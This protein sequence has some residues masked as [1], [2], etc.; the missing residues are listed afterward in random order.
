MSNFGPWAFLTAGVVGLVTAASVLIIDY[1]KQEKRRMIMSQEYNKLSAELAHLRQEL[2][3]L[4]EQQLNRKSQNGGVIRRRRAKTNETASSVGTESD[5]YI[6]AVGTDYESDEFYDLSSDEENDFDVNK[7]KY[8]ELEKM[9]VE[10]DRK[11]DGDEDDVRSALRTLRDLFTQYPEHTGV[12]WRFAKACH[13]LSECISDTKEKWKLID[14]G[15]EYCD[16]ALNHDK[17]AHAHKWYAILI[18]SRSTLQTS[19]KEKIND[20][21]TFKEHL[22][23]ALKIDP[24]DWTLHYLYGRFQFEVAGLSWLERTAASTLFAEPPQGSY[25]EAI[26]SFHEAENLS[27]N[28]WKENRLLLGKSYLALS[29]YQQAVKWLR[30]ARDAPTVSLSD[31]IA[32]EEINKLLD[33]Y[34]S[35]SI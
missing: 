10:L 19:T 12:Y 35:Y 16:R 25:E 4:R 32:D 21:H 3:L 33:K 20:G 28:P 34:E 2:D 23:K 13:R 26:N 17:S 5:A 8:S 11:L 7:S 22:D 31:K 27:P 9:L 1:F 14:E 24:K 6:S 18:G 30:N 15:L 29:N